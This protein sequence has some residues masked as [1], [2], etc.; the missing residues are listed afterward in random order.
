M[1]REFID[2]AASYFGM[3]PARLADGALF[4]NAEGLTVTLKVK[5]TNDDI[6]GVADRMRALREPD[7]E[8]QAGW[9][10]G[11]GNAVFQQLPSMQEVMRNPVA[12]LDRPECEGMIKRAMQLSA[13]A[14]EAV[15]IE[16]MRREAQPI[17]EAKQ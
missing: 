8:Q 4:S 11:D 16:L 10:D 2:A 12:Y 14:N 3:D 1:T 17:S 9:V 13:S 5:L 7:P 6:I 15:T